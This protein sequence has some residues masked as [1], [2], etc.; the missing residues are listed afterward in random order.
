MSDTVMSDDD[1]VIVVP[2]AGTKKV[3]HYGSLEE[4]ERA[5]LAAGT[6]VGSPKPSANIVSSSDYM[7]LEKREVNDDKRALLDE[8]ERRKRARQIHV[9]TDDAEVKRRLRQRDQPIC[10]FGEGP[11]DRRNRLRDLLSRDEDGGAP[12]APSAETES[13]P[14]EQPRTETWYHEGPAELRQARLW[15]AGYSLPR[16]KARLAAARERLQTPEPTRN[17]ERQQLQKQLR[18]LGLHA[19]QVGDTRPVS[20]CAFSP[21]GRQLATASWSGLCKVWSVPDCQP[22]RTLRGHTCNVGAVSWHPA[23]TVSLQPSDVNLASCGHDGT[24]KLW[25]LDS[26][27]PLADIEGHAPYRVSSV[28]YHPSGRFLASCCYD[29]SWRLWDLEQLTEVLHQEGHSGPVYDVDF[30]SDGSLAATGGLDA[31]AR[32]WDLR[33]GSC[34]MFMEGHLKGVLSIAFSPNGYLVATGSS[35]NTCK[36]WDIRR[37]ECFYTVPAHTNLVSSVAFGPDRG[38]FLATASYDA[39]A[40]IWSA[41]TWQPLHTLKGHDGKIMCVAISPDGHCVATSSYDRTFKLWMPE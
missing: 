22:Q 21:D 35:D 24:V 16:A 15:I 34:I 13:A 36:V 10:L 30:H 12:E 7:E 20:H 33:T 9:S 2:P 6:G 26:E 41:D 32:L 31:Y 8:F 39:T 37:R 4:T 14:Q 29:N 17:A 1:D 28:K 40:K 3:V 18:A 38:A 19:S 11:A 23:A 27:E 5:R 25:S